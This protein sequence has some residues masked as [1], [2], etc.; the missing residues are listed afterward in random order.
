MSSGKKTI[1][2]VAVLGVASGALVWHM[3]AWHQSGMHLEMFQWPGTGKG[4]LTALYNLAVML[5]LGG[6]LGVLVDRIGAL[7]RR[8]SGERGPDDGEDAVNER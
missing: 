8:R 2:W 3:V 1:V 5:V 7:L 6:L 4:Y